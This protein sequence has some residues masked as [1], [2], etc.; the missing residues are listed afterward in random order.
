ML[1][2]PLGFLPVAHS[3]Y[4]RKIFSYFQQREGRSNHF[5]MHQSI[6]FFLTMSVLRRNYLP[7]PKPLGFYQ[8]LNYLGEKKYSISAHL[9]HPVL[10]KMV[11]VE[12][13]E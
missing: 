9:S 11:E 2:L 1:A 13:G 12:V 8:S 3:E 6:P 7:E 4:W 10:G 5:E